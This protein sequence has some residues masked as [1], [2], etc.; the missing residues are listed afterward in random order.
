MSLHL[1]IGLIGL[2]YI[3][4][5]GVMSLLRREGLS[6]RFAVESVCLTAIV[7]ILVWLT[8]VQ[9]H[10]VLFLLLLVYDHIPRADIG[11]PGEYLCQ[12]GKLRSS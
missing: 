4:V 7:V 3:V 5:F 12:T 2:L 1:L 6:I 8:P 10:P 11:R 9:I